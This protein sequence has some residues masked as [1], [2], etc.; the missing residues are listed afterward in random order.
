MPSELSFLEWL[1][2]ADIL[3][4]RDSEIRAAGWPSAFSLNDLAYLQYP[5]TTA[6]DFR[7]RIK[8]Q[9]ARDRL[10]E[11]MKASIA[12]GTLKAETRRKEIKKAAFHAPQPS[13]GL[14]SVAWRSRDFDSQDEQRVARARYDAQPDVTIVA[15][16]V[17]TRKAFAAWGGLPDQKQSAH[18]RAWFDSGS[19]GSV[20]TGKKADNSDSP[21]AALERVLA[22]CE[23]RAEKAREP[24]DVNDM[25]GQIAQ[26][27]GLCQRLE[28]VFKRQTSVESFRRYTKSGRCAWSKSAKSNPN[29]TPLYQKLFP[30]AWSSDGAF[31]K[32]AS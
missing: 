1:E 2:A 4:V 5:D 8:Q 19:G 32:E 14:G 27:W 26:F 30:E 6:N 22:E 10:I 3:M 29:A 7:L 18:V 28:P 25:P 21:Y 16:E 12:M 31:S 9:D 24:F 20:Q 11:A 23:K 15:D 17:V 13:A